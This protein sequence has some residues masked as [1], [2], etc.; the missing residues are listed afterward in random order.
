MFPCAQVQTWCRWELGALGRLLRPSC[1]G[2]GGLGG[3]PALT[4]EVLLWADQAS[5]V[6]WA[7][8]KALR[9]AASEKASVWGGLTPEN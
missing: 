3:D 7:V 1:L 8:G 4:R 6:S 9:T 2:L 5:G